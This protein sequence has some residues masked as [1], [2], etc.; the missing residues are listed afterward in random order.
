MNL[1]GVIEYN[2]IVDD[3]NKII[4]QLSSFTLC[5]KI[6][7][8]ETACK[9]GN[10]ELA[11]TILFYCHIKD[12]EESLSPIFS[13]CCAKG[14]LHI[15]K[16]LIDL[17]PEINI[18][19]DNDYAFLNA[20]SN[21]YLDI[22]QW[23]LEIN[24][25]IDVTIKNNYAIINASMN[26]HINVVNWLIK[27]YPNITL[28][29]TVIDFVIDYITYRG[30]FEILKILYG[31]FTSSF[32]TEVYETAFRRAC[33]AGYL[34]IAQWVLDRNPNINIY[35]NAYYG[36][37]YAC[38]NGHI[39]V[40]RWFL[41][42]NNIFGLSNNIFE[43]SF[44]YACMN[45]YIDICKLLLEHHPYILITESIFSCSCQNGHLILSKWLY[46]LIQ[47][48][49][50]YKSRI[51][52]TIFKLTCKF[53]HL[54]VAKWLYEIHPNM[55]DK[56][57]NIAFF[58]ACKNNHLEMAKWLID[59]KPNLDVE[60]EAFNMLCFNNNYETVQW[61][62]KIRPYYYNITYSDNFNNYIIEWSVNS[63]Q[64]RKWL[65]RKQVLL[66]YYKDEKCSFRMLNPDMI[67]YICKFI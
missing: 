66:G 8:F 26:G 25:S 11:K 23:L 12:L 9:L 1:F 10:I 29:T 58:Y 40:I 63:I 49:N 37:K 56:T 13:L 17:C 55:S 42:N 62:I 24:P 46:S 2:N 14:Q 35:S 67:R 54:D 32:T 4:E 52:I 41:L 44:Q 39:H 50:Y 30:Y 60:I 43:I 7:A 22:A 33:S 18:S 53:N 27:T 16:W 21:G 65:E 28:S 19:R 36:F 48:L 59:V 51:D 47:D 6:N 3:Q 34:E 61:L 45:G 5:E 38:L 57:F 31:N 20:C 64:E 15:A